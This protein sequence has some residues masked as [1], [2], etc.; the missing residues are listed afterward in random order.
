MAVMVIGIK[1]AS[2]RAAEELIRQR[3]WTGMT[4]EQVLERPYAFIG[5]AEQ[6]AE[7]I[8]MMR[9]RCVRSSYPRI[10]VVPCPAW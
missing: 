10:V 6:I 7:K 2:R 1:V 4:V 8:E 9:E 5:S 3:G